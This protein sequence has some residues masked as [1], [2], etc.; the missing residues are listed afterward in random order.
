MPATKAYKKPLKDQPVSKEIN[1]VPKQC[2][3][4]LWKKYPT[5]NE[6]KFLS[7]SQS[8]IDKHSKKKKID[9]QRG[10]QTRTDPGIIQIRELASKNIKVVTTTIFHIFNRLK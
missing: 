7:D 1:N 6:V 10:N 5:S 9:L 3:E 2:Q 4:Y 8:E